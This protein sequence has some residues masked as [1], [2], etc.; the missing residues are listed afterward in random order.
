MFPCG[1]YYSKYIVVL[2]LRPIY[3]S[4][5]FWC[6]VMIDVYI[7]AF[8]VFYLFVTRVTLSRYDGP[9]NRCGPK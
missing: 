3:V 8:F 6:S 1:D 2:V 4:S 9:E 7:L 5:F